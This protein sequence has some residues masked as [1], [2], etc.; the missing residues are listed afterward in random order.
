M[1]E[2]QIIAQGKPVALF[3]LPAL[4]GRLD[5]ARELGDTIE[6]LIAF[7]DDMGGDPD[8]EDGYDAE[9]DMSDYEPDDDAKGDVSWTEWDTRARHKLQG[10]HEPI[11]RANGWTALEDDEDDD[12]D[13]GVEDDPRG[14]DPEQDLGAEEAGEGGS[15]PETAGGYQGSGGHHYDDDDHEGDATDTS[16]AHRDYIRRTRCESY[17]R[18]GERRYRLA[19]QP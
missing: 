11:R 19:Q 6:G 10:D 3:D 15:W 8:L 14:F 13:T 16:R 7:M 1:L 12:A 17:V 2:L 18:Y 4:L 5:A 9:R